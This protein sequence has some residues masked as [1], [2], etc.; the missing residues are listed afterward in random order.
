MNRGGSTQKVVVVGAGSSA[1]RYVR[2]F[3]G[4]RTLVAVV[5]S[6]GEGE[7]LGRPVETLDHLATVNFDRLVIASWAIE[8]LTLEV[9]KRG[10]PLEAI[11]IFF[12]DRDRIESLSAWRASQSL[13]AG[14]FEDSA[15]PLVWAFYDL[16]V[17]RPTFDIL[18]FL[19]LAERAR[20]KRGCQGFHLVVVPPSLNEFNRQLLPVFDVAEQRWRIHQILLQA[21]A[22]VPGCRGVSLAPDRETASRWAEAQAQEFCFPEGYRES[23]PIP[24]WEFENVVEAVDRGDEVRYL[25]ASRQAHRAIAGWAQAVVP[26]GRR[27]ISVTLRDCSLQQA[28]NSDLRAWR[29][30]METLDRDRF[31]PVVI[32][33]TENALLPSVFT[34]IACVFPVAAF[35]LDLRLALYETSFINMGVANGPTHLWVFSRCCAY[36]MFKQIVNEYNHSSEASF[37]RRRLT[38]GGQ[39]PGAGPWQRLVWEEDDFTV[40]R[41]A[42]ER[43]CEDRERFSQQSPL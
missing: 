11:D 25:E 19:C 38:I 41:D 39:F 10:V 24:C 6:R 14:Y 26:P 9:Q 12:N 17:A 20:R 2:D 16:N 42:F 8:E 28:R 5:D 27:M 7:L 4:D 34:D 32:P 31:F 22:L 36:L 15:A 21:S 23:A 33:D 35:N 40:I 1:R 3:L 43:L 13:S 29:D 37:K 18:A 30:F